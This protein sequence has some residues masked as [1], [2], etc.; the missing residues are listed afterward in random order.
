MST[1]EVHKSFV[2][3]HDVRCDT[4]EG[5][6]YVAYEK[7]FY[8]YTDFFVGNFW[9]FFDWLHLYIKLPG[10]RPYTTRIYPK[11]S[12]V[13][14]N[15]LTIYLDLNIPGGERLF[16]F[17]FLAWCSGGINLANMQVH[18]WWPVFYTSTLFWTHPGGRSNDA[19]LLGYY[20]ALIPG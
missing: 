7:G 18:H 14:A 1:H 2:K 19:H 9:R 4:Q 11:T 13:T 17:N 6:S 5:E 16:Y 3:K 10:Q 20:L 15:L 12:R 8:Q